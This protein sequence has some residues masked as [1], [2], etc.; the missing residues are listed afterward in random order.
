ME[1]RRRLGSAKIIVC[2]HTVNWSIVILRHDSLFSYH[3]C[4]IPGQALVLAQFSL[5]ACNA[6][7]PRHYMLLTPHRQPDTV[8]PTSS[9]QG[10]PRPFLE[11]KSESITP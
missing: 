5:T 9:L 2:I 6:R 11:G 7:L 10:N 1:C 8:S 3:G 4:M